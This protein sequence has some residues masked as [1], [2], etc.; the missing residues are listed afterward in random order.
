MYRLPPLVRWRLNLLSSPPLPRPP[1]PPGRSHLLI[2]ST[3]FPLKKASSELTAAPSSVSERPP[4]LALGGSPDQ[5]CFAHSASQ[6][7]PVCFLS[8]LGRR[9]R[10]SQAHARTTPVA[11]RLVSVQTA[12]PVQSPLPGCIHIHGPKALLGSVTSLFEKSF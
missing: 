5:V 2:N 9:S 7:S 6:I 12:L 10:P 3:H 1:V 4:T 8:I 11:S